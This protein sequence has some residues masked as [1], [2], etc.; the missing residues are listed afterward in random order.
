MKLTRYANVFINAI[1]GRCTSNCVACT[2]TLLRGRFTLKDVT[3]AEHSDR[4]T[5]WMIRL[6]MWVRYI[7]SVVYSFEIRLERL[8]LKLKAPLVHQSTGVEAESQRKTLDDNAPDSRNLCE[9]Q[10]RQKDILLR[11]FRSRCGT[12]DAPEH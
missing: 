2:I 3:C 9:P 11:H 10:M 5:F 4:R 8:H 12:S 7:N 1:S 6:K